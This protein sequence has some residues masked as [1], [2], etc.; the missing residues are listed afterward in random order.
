MRAT[1]HSLMLLPACSRAA[2]LMQLEVAKVISPAAEA[3]KDP[4][5]EWDAYRSNWYDPRKS[6]QGATVDAVTLNAAEA[7]QLALPR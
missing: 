5:S 3:T 1:T 7:G 6:D 4:R 2:G